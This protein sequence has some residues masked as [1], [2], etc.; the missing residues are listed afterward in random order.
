MA[1]GLDANCF[2]EAQG[3]RE[4]CGA[5]GSRSCS[6]ERWDVQR[7]GCV[8][9]QA[10]VLT[11][12][13]LLGTLERVAMNGSPPHQ[14]SPTSALGAS[15]SPKRFKSRVTQCTQDALGWHRAVEGAA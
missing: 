12:R 8:M 11:A 7:R 6:R 1:I 9:R 2:E 5:P 13:E 10:L 14:H 3:L 4:K 15:W